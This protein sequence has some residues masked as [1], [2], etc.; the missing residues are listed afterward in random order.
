MM[1]KYGTFSASNVSYS[2]KENDYLQDLDVEEN[3]IK[4][5]HEEITWDNV[6]WIKLSQAQ[7][8]SFC[9][10]VYEI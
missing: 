3:N 2:T 1:L 6:Y 5:D 9:E 8:V 4:M 10:N 7:E